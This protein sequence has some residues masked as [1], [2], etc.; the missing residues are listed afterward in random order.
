MKVNLQLC[1]W[2]KPHREIFFFQENIHP[3]LKAKVSRIQDENA[4][5]SRKK[6]A[7]EEREVNIIVLISAWSL[8]KRMGIV[9]LH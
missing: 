3:Y 8:Y 2:F 9:N 6:E 4:L 5:K 1:L 7:V